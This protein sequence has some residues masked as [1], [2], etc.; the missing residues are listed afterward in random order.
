MNTPG[1]VNRAKA[2]LQSAWHIQVPFHWLEACINWIQQDNAGTVLTQAEINKQVLEQWLLTDLR[3]LEQPILPRGISEAA[4]VE[5]NG[6]YC[7][8]IDSLLDVSQ[9]AYSQIQKLKGKDFTNENVT[10]VT[11][12][13]QKPWEAKPLRMLMLQLTDGV[14]QLQGM[15]YQP[16]PD[17]HANLSPGSKILLQGKIVCRLGVLLLTPLNVK[18]IGGEVEGL[19][20]EFSQERVLSRVLGETE[21][22]VQRPS[23]Q[24]REMPNVDEGFENLTSP[25]GEELLASIETVDQLAMSNV[26]GHDSGY[27][28]RSEVSS[29]LTRNSTLQSYHSGLSV[30][31]S[32][33]TQMVPERASE[34]VLELDDADFDDIPVDDLDDVIYLEDSPP[35][36]ETPS[37]EQSFLCNQMTMSGN[38][39]INS[40]NVPSTLNLTNNMVEV[41]ENVSGERIVSIRPQIRTMTNDGNS[42]EV[43]ELLEGSLTVPV[44]M[45]K[46]RSVCESSAIPSHSASGVNIKPVV[47]C[48]S[49]ENWQLGSA[50]HYESC[51]EEESVPLQTDVNF[52]PEMKVDLNSCPFSYLSVLL[53]EKTAIVKVV[54][55]KAFIVT[56][57]GSL[58]SS[59][60]SWHIKV[61]I[62]D[63]TDYLDVDLS[64]EV[65]VSL[66]GFTVEETKKMKKDPDQRKR[67][68]AG[69]QKCQQELIDLCCIMTIEYDPCNSKAVL[70]GL[71][72]VTLEDYNN[73]EKRLQN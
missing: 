33:T 60:G 9:P 11:Q 50:V 6:F 57:L 58:S 42:I 73:L 70:L 71:Q 20:E 65:L 45:S 35:E 32:Q 3:D 67:V 30:P 17:L 18:V 10:A 61:K 16:I 40:R 4:K 34:E 26:V 56:L 55:V 41:P 39:N 37:T 7:L 43:P 27:G 66:I 23:S 12:V 13:S 25:S 69:L 72:D 1:F 22:A 64:N 47:K 19:V 8:Q 14:Q 28:S 49:F 54:K 46:L 36:F 31:E 5:I 53:G 24:D 51:E 68:T 21:N 15:E 48:Q 44:E 29:V 63:G 38:S 52:Q 59:S 62:S 2:W